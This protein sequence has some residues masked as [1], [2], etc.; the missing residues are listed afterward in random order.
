M[1]V[2]AE[3]LNCGQVGMDWWVSGLL[4]GAHNNT[5]HQQHFIVQPCASAQKPCI[6]MGGCVRGGGVKYKYIHWFKLYAT[7]R[8]KK[9]YKKS[10]TPPNKCMHHTSQRMRIQI[11]SVSFRWTWYLYLPYSRTHILCSRIVPGT[12]Y[13]PEISATPG[14]SPW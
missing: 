13:Q 1:R 12:W 14:T 9:S 6:K 2:S 8:C 4:R 7:K 11:F 3:T 5:V 10:S